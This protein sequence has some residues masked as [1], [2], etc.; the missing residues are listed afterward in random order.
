MVQQ[1]ARKRI[2]ILTVV[3]SLALTAGLALAIA[4]N[5]TNRGENSNAA[6]RVAACMATPAPGLAIGENPDS[7]FARHGYCICGCGATCTS[8]ADCGGAACVPY[9][10][11]C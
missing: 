4:P 1:D 9:I 5:L 3:V 7:E 2:G 8:S 6:D 10:T 11:C